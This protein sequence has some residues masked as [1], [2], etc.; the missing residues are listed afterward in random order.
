MKKIIISGASGF[1]GKFVLNFLKNY[2]VDIIDQSKGHNICSQEFFKA[3]NNDYDV[4]IH[5]AG[6]TNVIDSFKN[7]L[8]YYECN[9]IGALNIAKFCNLKKIGK[10]IYANSYPYGSPQYLPVDED[11]SINPQ[12]PYQKSKQ[13]AENILLDIPGVK[14][15]SCRLFNVYG[16]GQPSHLLMPQIIKQ[17]LGDNN[18]IEVKDTLPKR[19]YIYIEDIANLFLSIIKSN[20]NNSAIINVGTGKSYSV[21]EV[22]DQIQKIIGTKKEI[23]SQNEVRR[24]EVMDCYAKITKAWDDFNWEPKIQL[25]EGLYKWISQLKIK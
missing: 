14:T 18:F 4:F 24:N 11:H 8:D 1:I 9:T 17:A 10:I 13:F 23:I 7:P 3:F 5:L 15:I 2:E 19:D 12:S 21:K 16:P 6:K 20:V 22:I 25:N